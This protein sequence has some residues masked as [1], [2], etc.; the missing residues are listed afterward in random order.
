MNDNMN[1]KNEVCKEALFW[2]MVL[3]RLFDI[4]ITH[5]ISQVD[6]KKT[7]VYLTQEG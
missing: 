3:Q 5:A 6:D 4:I 2:K 1:L 7:S